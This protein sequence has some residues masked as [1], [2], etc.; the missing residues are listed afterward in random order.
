MILHYQPRFH[1]PEQKVHENNLQFRLFEPIISR[2]YLIFLKDYDI[3]W[4]LK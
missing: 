2:I 1:F 3:E 4:S